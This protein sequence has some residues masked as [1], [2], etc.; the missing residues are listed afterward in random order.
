MNNEKTLS[1]QL[2]IQANE[3]KRIGNMAVR[4]A[5]DENRRRGIPNVFSRNGQ[6]YYELPNGEITRE[7]PFKALL[8][9]N[10][11]GDE[12]VAKATT[13]SRPSL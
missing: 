12:T 10:N 1:L 11:N 9:K 3:F 8:S 7:D 5:L 2:F 13:T 6:I 4:K